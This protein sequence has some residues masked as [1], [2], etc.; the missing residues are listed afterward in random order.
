M[1]TFHTDF[2]FFFAAHLDP[3]FDLPTPTHINQLHNNNKNTTNTNRQPH[4]VH[5]AHLTDDPTK[6]DI[7]ENNMYNIISTTTHSTYIPKV[8]SPPPYDAMTKQLHVAPT[9]SP[10]HFGAHTHEITCALPEFP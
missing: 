3:H 9:L 2:L 1:T 5:T 4:L 10:F 6:E 8:P 7:H